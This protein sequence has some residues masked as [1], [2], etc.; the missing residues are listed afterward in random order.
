MTYRGG[1]S[2]HLAISP[3]RDDELEPGRGDVLSISYRRIAR[4]DV[5]RLDEPRPG[6]QRHPVLEPDSAPKARER[7]SPRNTLHLHEV[8]LRKFPAGVRYEMLQGARI[9]QKKK[10]FAVEIEPSRR[11]NAGNVDEI[12]ERA[13]PGA[14]TAE[15]AEHPKRFVE[16]NQSVLTRLQDG[17][18][19]R[20][21][22]SRLRA[23]L[24]R[25]SP[26]RIPAVAGCARGTRARRDGSPARE[27]SGS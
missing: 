18:H 2:S 23:S 8:R 13:A 27:S 24:S 21:S 25:I 4:P 14:F 17:T 1:H 10:P 11:V 20:R 9:G 3:L 22:L 12:R 16:Q 7:D 6:G 15:L 5:G 26:S 19:P